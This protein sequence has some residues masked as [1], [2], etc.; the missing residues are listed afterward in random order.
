MWA[1]RARTVEVVLPRTDGPDERRPLRLV[2]AHEPGYWRA[3]DELAPGTEYA[4]S[5]DAGTALPDPCSTSMPHGP[6]RPGRVLDESYAWHDES[7]RG[8]DLRRG[9]LL[10]L[11]VAG[12]TPEGTLD[13]AAGL[14]PRVAA[15]GVD[16]VELG[17]V[18]AHD[19]D[20]GLSGGA[21]LFAVH[22]PY[23]GAPALARFV[24]AAHRAGLAVVLDLPHRWAVADRLDLH[25]FAP[26]AV[27]ARLP[28]RAGSGVTSDTP[29][30][31]LDGSGSRGTRDFLVADARRWLEDYHVDGLLLDVEVLTDRSAVPFLAELA[32][33]AQ[34]VGARTGVPRTF[35]TDGVGRSDR[36]TTAVATMLDGNIAAAID[37]MQRIWA[38][39]IGDGSAVPGMA[40]L[41]GR[42]SRGPRS[43]TLVDDITRLPA[44][45]RQVSWSPDRD[46]GP[47]APSPD[48]VAVLL[49]LATLA[50]TPL[51]LDTEHVPLVGD[52]LAARRLRDW[53]RTLLRLRA[54]ALA[55]LHAG[56]DLHTDGRTL[57]ARRGESAILVNVDDRATDVDLEQHLPDPATWQV[58]ASWRL[59]ETHLVAGRLKIPARTPVVLRTDR[60]DPTPDA[61]GAAP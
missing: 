21:R 57:V 35:L 33:T 3:D 1:P 23:G 61:P 38:E 55:D 39:F 27:G 42:R 53:A 4:F 32:E 44:A 5:I 60:A 43:G 36:L 51:V 47:S 17:P 40:G 13:A 31:N 19:P 26:Y 7:W 45:A 22:E 30:V 14:L 11:D 56:V 58:A 54:P 12:A 6:Y 48:D 16:A 49:T 50:G 2:G 46:A 25:A 8:A 29:R 37:S 24:D 52:T 15:L 59:D 18:A 34:D 20:H 10:H 28:P 41:P 9:A